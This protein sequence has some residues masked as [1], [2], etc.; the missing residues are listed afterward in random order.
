MADH[1]WRDPAN[2]V[3]GM[4]L[5][6]T[7]QPDEAL[8]LLLNGGGR[9]RQFMVPKLD[10]TGSWSEV[11]STSHA[12]VSKELEGSVQLNARSLILLRYRFPG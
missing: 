5:R 12:T 2:H 6:G 1:D 10:D 4:L 9:A 11:V 7:Q 8:L 3:L